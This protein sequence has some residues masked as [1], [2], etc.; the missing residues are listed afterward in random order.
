MV[1]NSALAPIVETAAGR[2]R[3]LRTR[4]T[5]VFKGIPYGA[6]TAGA[7]RF[8]APRPVAP[9]AGV[10]DTREFG[11]SAPQRP[12]IV[13]PAFAWYFSEI[14]WSED[15][16]VL[17]VF[18]PAARD[19][20]KR[21][22]MVWFHGGGFSSGAG[23]AKGFDGTNLAL[24]GDV[25]VITLNHRLN[26]FGHFFP[27]SGGETFRDSGNAGELDLIAALIWV[28]DNISQF[29]GDP[30]N[31]TIFGQSGGA[32]KV[33]TLLAMPAAHGLFH[34]AIIQSASSLIR[35]AE[36]ENTA[37]A[38]HAVLTRLDISS[39][40]A[41][42][43]VPA[44]ALLTAMAETIA[45]DG[46]DHFRPVRDGIWLLE[47]PFAPTAP[48][49]SADIPLLIGTA[50]DEA[51]FFLINDPANFSMTRDQ[52]VARAGR[53]VGLADGAALFAEYESRRP[54]ATPSQVYI[55]IQSDHMYRRNDILAAELRA[56]QSGAETFMYFFDWKA[57]V[58]D[59]ILGVPHTIEVPFAFGNANLVPELVGTGPETR[60]LQ[61]KVMG[62]W[63][64]FARDGRP[65]APELPDWAPFSLAGRETM[66]F[67]DTCRMESDPAREDRLAI[68]TCP[69]YRPE[70]SGRR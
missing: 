8:R 1:E 9:W 21:P 38:A 63:T 41:L 36:P 13:H 40:E 48:A 2:I 61:R 26:L 39:Y 17:N 11:A 58:L 45:A 30:G 51:T 70:A 65:S 20:A 14:P 57:P 37:R 69:P 3:G 23:S 15:C 31:V 64:S 56:R 53:F 5:D 55:A 33:A 47:H 12:W 34:R 46:A 10:R 35:A 52:A 66:I 19:A 68:E 4:G 54:G 44:Q 60:D 29:G 18:A 62:A 27:D 49:L 43:D 25:V 24:G 6:S 59:G 32:S 50:R 16:L 7:N 67:A 28:R 42:R 22:V